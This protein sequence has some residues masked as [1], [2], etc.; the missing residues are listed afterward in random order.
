MITTM[1]DVLV[2]TP[3]FGEH[4]SLPWSELEAAGLRPRRPQAAHPLSSRQLCEEIGDAEALLVGLDDLDAAAIAAGPKL[5]VIAKHGV[6]VDNIDVAAATARGVTVTNAPGANSGAVADLVMGMTLTMARQLLAAH[7]SVTAGGWYRFFGPELAGKTMAILGF[8][9]IGREVFRRACG[10]GM[11]VL[12][13]DPYV[14]DGT[15]RASGA[16][17][18]DRE[19]ALSAGHVVTMHLPS[20]PDGGPL[21]DRGQL[22]RMRTS[23][24]LVNTARGAL[25][26]EVA[27]ADALESGKLAGYAADAFAH[28]PPRESPLLAAPNAVLTPHIGAFTDRANETMG[29]MVVRDVARVLRGEPPEYPVRP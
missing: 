23:A 15:V 28:E 16:K 19:T 4:S 22:A 29:T 7:Q 12:A 2:L 8:G 11:T 24:Y 5:K 26:D 1:R 13:H 14:P 9:R 20:A 27:V 10:F 25:V 21:I 3:S 6:G 17:P 18:V